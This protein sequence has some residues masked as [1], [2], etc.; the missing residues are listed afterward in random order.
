MTGGQAPDQKATDEPLEGRCGA[1]LRRHPGKYCGKWPVSGRTR[2]RMHGGAT[3]IAGPTHPTFKHGR[4]SKWTKA[5]GKLGTLYAEAKESEDLFDLR[6]QIAVMDVAVQ[7]HAARVSDLDTP[8]FRR[9]ALEL[10]REAR[11]SQDA[12]QSARALGEL[13]RLLGR[14]AAEDAS[15]E[16]LVRTADTMARRIEAAYG[17]KLR[18]DEVVNQA[19]LTRIVGALV[20]IM[21]EEAPS[22]VAARVVNR[23]DREIFEGRLTSAGP[24][25]GGASRGPELDGEVPGA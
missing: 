12:E 23:A 5:L 21:V 1:R 10:Y 22:D 7:R 25:A 2:C 14:G 15:F 9:R 8:D 19:E 17:I 24:G 4:Q 6:R 16:A 3:P 20:S 18:G 13:G 11:N